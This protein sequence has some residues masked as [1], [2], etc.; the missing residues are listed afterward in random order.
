MRMLF[1]ISEHTRQDRI[2]N[3]K[4]NIKEKVGAAS[5]AEMMTE[6]RFRWFGHVRR[7]L[8]AT[9]RVN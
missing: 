3:K 6:A 2:R 4:K 8:V 5:I 7:A 9:I 1:C